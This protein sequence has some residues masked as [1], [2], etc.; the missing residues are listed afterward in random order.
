VKTGHGRREPRQSR[1]EKAAHIRSVIRVYWRTHSERQMAEMAGCTH[2]T[3][4]NHRQKMEDSGDIVPRIDESSH[5]I[6]ARFHEV[7]TCA[8]EPASENDTL[9]DPVREDDPAFLALV[10]DIRQN[11]IINPIGVSADGY[12]YDGH[13]A[14]EDGGGS[15][16]RK[17]RDHETRVVAAGVRLP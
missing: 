13:A 8:I 7:A 3:I 10:E 11:G 6:Q 12:I 14:G 2:Q 16:P 5:S 1:A 4:R 15:D 9:Y 17:P